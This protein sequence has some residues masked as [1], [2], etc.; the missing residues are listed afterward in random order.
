MRGG[1]AEQLRED[2]PDFVGHIAERCNIG[3]NGTLRLTW[4]TTSYTFGQRG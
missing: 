2:L 4:S 3:E 1:D